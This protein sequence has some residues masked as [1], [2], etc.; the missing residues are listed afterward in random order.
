[1]RNRVPG[2]RV[3]RRMRWPPPREH[4][5]S[6][7]G[8]HSQVWA[9]SRAGSIRPV[10]LVPVQQHRPGSVVNGSQ[11]RAR[12]I[13]EAHGGG[14]VAAVPGPGQTVPTRAPLPAS[15]PAP[16][17]DRTGPKPLTTR[18]WPLRRLRGIRPR[19]LRKNLLADHGGHCYFSGGRARERGGGTR[20]RSIGM[21]APLRG[22]GQAIGRP[23]AP[24][25]STPERHDHAIHF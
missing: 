20:E 10:G 11:G 25:K 14:I 6:R 23:G 13:T 2:A 24:S 3:V 8:R 21:G 4:S 19:S 9:C 22:H 12:P 16:H 1:M 18:A 7:T 15:R 17:R 5:A